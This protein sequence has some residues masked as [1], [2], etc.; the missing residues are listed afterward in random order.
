MNAMK[1]V[2]M[3]CWIITAV[4]LTGIALW[5]FTG[6]IFG[7]WSFIENLTGPFETDG[8]YS[9]IAD[10]IDSININW[11]SGEVTVIP[12][13]GDDIKIIEYAQRKLSDN[14]KLRYTV[15]GS[16]LEI[17][18]RDRGFSGRMPRK[19]LEVFV[20]RELSENMTLLSVNS[21]SGSIRVEDFETASL[22]LSSVSGAISISG[23]VSP[24]IDLGTTSGAVNAASVR[25]GRLDAGTVSGAIAITDSLISS[26]NLSTTSGSSSASGDFD[27]VDV[28]TVSGGTTIRSS[29]VP[30]R[31][32]VSSVSGGASVYIPNQGAITV[33]HSAVSGRF[34]SE[35]PV[36]M[37]SGAAF[38]FSSV[39]GSTNIYALG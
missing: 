39:S 14:E 10:G 30:S 28:S 29:T 18:F 7:D 19:R 38:N 8:T 33:S 11:V 32:G 9:V 13:D 34:S 3:I 26:V 16:T 17:R 5:F 12:H 20:P 1:I 31:L 2:T 4:V 27:K 35:V 15:S 21:T 37:Q 6:D 22:N 25:A 36:T 24:R 23:I